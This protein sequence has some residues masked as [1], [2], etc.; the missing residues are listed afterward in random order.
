M[1]N[2]NLQ[3]RLS[4]L[5]FSRNLSEKALTRLAE[6]STRNVYPAGS[7]IFKEGDSHLHLHVVVEGRVALDMHVP[8]RGDV[9]IL[10]LGSGELLGWSPILGD[11]TMS[12]TA[13]CL[14]DTETVA[15]SAAPLVE[16]CESDPEVGYQVMR[17]IVVA[18]SERLVATR[19]QLLDLFAETTPTPQG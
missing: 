5:A 11:N 2:D 7:V 18:M 4:T 10:S 6:I 15:I 14:K 1:A 8:T 16:L 13:T 3:A 17:Q 19:L 12:A 9:R